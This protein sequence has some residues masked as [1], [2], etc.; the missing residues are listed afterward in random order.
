MATK[1]Q[2]FF[3]EGSGRIEN[4]LLRR[5]S[6]A[7]DDQPPAPEPQEETK[8]SMRQTSVY[9]SPDQE[10]WLDDRHRE[11][12]RSRGSGALKKTAIMRALL[13]LAM[14]K[15]INLAGVHTEQDLVARLRDQLLT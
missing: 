3:K 10:E 7:M 9:L 5:T 2:Q 13:T 6:V 8:V 4:P 12:R 15:E 11:I 14:E 1:K